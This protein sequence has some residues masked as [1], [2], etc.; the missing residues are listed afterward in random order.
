MAMA[1]Y[2]LLRTGP[3]VPLYDEVCFD[4]IEA[5]VAPQ[6]FAPNRERDV[7]NRS[8]PSST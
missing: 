8:V 4:I 5:R 1:F 2:R 6:T 3:E 7:S